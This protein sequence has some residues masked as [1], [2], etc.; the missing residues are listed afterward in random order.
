M[1]EAQSALFPNYA[2]YPFTFVKGE[3]SRLWDENGK[4]YL[5]L[6]CGL[7]V[8]NLGHAP[9]QV[10]ERLKEQVDTLWHTSNLFH[11]PGQE[12]LAQLLVENS[13]TDAVFFCNSGAEANEAAIKIARRY[14]QKVINQPERYEII[15]FNMS[16]HGRTLATLTA[17]GQDK[18]KEGFSPLPEGFVYAPY[19]DA[20]AVEKLITGKTCAIMLELVQGEGGVIPADPDFVKAV[21]NLCERHGLLLILDEIQTGIGRTGKL[22]A[23]E[24]F[25]IE[26]DLVTLAKGLGS[27]MPIGALLGKEKLRTAFAAGSHGTTFGG[28]YLSTAAGLATLETM[29]Q[30]NVSER[31]AEMGSYIMSELKS[32]LAGNPLV[33]TIRGLGMLIGIQ[34][35][36]SGAEL[37][38]SIHEQG[39]L[40]VPA[41]PNVI[42]LAPSLLISKEDIDRGLDTICQTLAKAAAAAV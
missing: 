19:N 11:I 30:E 1:G 4:E 6:M 18:V 14:Y 35:T 34:L 9:K 28:N 15:T 33:E 12:R 21:A 25:G 38:K 10:T 20:D 32:R 23:Y 3:G 41:G 42:R 17:T 7:A 8:T 5:D 36:G 31:A 39:V 2:R 22:F 37:I 29:L 24:H 13:C 40:V 16:F 26:P 27:G